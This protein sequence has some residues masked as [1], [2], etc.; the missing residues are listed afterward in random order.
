MEIY[1]VMLEPITIP[2]FRI[3]VEC[4]NAEKEILIFLPNPMIKDV[5]K[6]FAKIRILKF[7]NDEGSDK[8]QP[9]HMILRAVDYQRIKT[10]EPVVLGKNPD[11]CV[12]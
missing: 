3:K 2:E 6:R 1:N 5:K 10:T 11:K 9:V 4:T 7:S 8:L 12:V